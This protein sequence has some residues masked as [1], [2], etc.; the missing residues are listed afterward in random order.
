MGK[1]SEMLSTTVTVQDVDAMSKNLHKFSRSLG[2]LSIKIEEDDQNSCKF[3]HV[4]EILSDRIS[5]LILP[6]SPISQNLSLSYIYDSILSSWISSLPEAVPSRVRI[7]AEKDARDIAVQL[8]LSGLGVHVGSRDDE[9]NVVVEEPRSSLDGVLN[10][11]LRKNYSLPRLSVEH[12]EKSERRSSSPLF[13]SQISEDAGYVLPLFGSLP[14]PEP[15]PSLRSKSPSVVDTEDPASKRLRAFA[16]LAPQPNLPLSASNILRHWSEGSD[17]AMYDFEATERSIQ[18]ELES[19]PLD[20]ARA[21][22]QQRKEKRLK[23]QRERAIASTSQP[24]PTRI[25]ASQSLAQSEPDRS[26]DLQQL[27][28]QVTEHLAFFSQT[29]KGASGRFSVGKPGNWKAKGKIGKKRA[30]GF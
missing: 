4:S 1:R 16:D 29:E 6:S 10:L 14:T 15:S 11:P 12:L 20:K 18:M 2:K 5:A 22:K 24:G 3:L 7:A 27:S 21:K 8:A 30:P 23:R 17:P 26:Q 28:S 25:R 13:S 19:E 9:E